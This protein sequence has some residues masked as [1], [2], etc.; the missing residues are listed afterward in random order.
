MEAFR[1]NLSFGSHQ[2]GIRKVKDIFNHG[3]F[4]KGKKKRGDKVLTNYDK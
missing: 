4:K 1:C 3:D 2:R